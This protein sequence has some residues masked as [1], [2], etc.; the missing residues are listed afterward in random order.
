MNSMKKLI[1]GTSLWGVG[2]IIFLILSFILS[3]D[4][5]WEPAAAMARNCAITAVVFAIFAA[6]SFFDQKLDNF[7][8]MWWN[9]GR[10]RGKEG[11]NDPND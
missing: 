10:E 9:R 4:F 8:T 11:S 5:D 3:F 1:T 2:A 7:I 6:V